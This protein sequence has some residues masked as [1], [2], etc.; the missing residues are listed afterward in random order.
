MG[1]FRPLSPMLHGDVVVDHAS[2]ERP[3]AIEGVDGHDVKKVI[4]LHPLEEIA[5]TAALELEDALGFPAA[6]ESECR[7]IG[8]RK[9]QRVGA[10][11]GGGGNDFDCLAHH[12]EKLQPQKVHLHQP[13]AFHVAHGPLRDHFL[14]ARHPLQRHILHQRPIG[15]HHRRRVRAHIAGQAL[16]PSGQIDQLSNLGIGF[17]GGGQL[18]ARRR[19]LLQRDAELIGH[20]RHNLINPLDRHAE[21]AAHVANGGP[22]GQRAKR[23]D[24]GHVGSPVAALHIFNHLAATFLAEID[25]DIGRLAPVDIEKPL[26]EQVVFQWADVREVEGVGHQRTNTRTSRRRWNP[27]LAGIAHE[28]PDNQEVTAKA[29]RVDDTHFPVKPIHHLRMERARFRAAGNR[30]IAPALRHAGIS[31]AQP[32]HAE[33]P[34]FVSGSAPFGH[35]ESREMAFA[36]IDLDI[37]GVGDLLA[38]G[39][40]CLGDLP[41]HVG[42]GGVHLGRTLQIKLRGVHPHPGG[43]AAE[44]AGVDAQEN[45]LGLGILAVDVVAVAGGHRRDAQFLRHF[46]SRERHLPLHLQAIVLNLDKIPIAKHL[47]KPSGGLPGLLHR[48]PLLTPHADQ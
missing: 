42:K 18:G 47:A 4:G 13:G 26:E 2:F 41:L 21:G 23:A 36:E 9:E 11:A 31:L 12:G 33:A 34:Q 17:A 27:H 22:G 14:L 38:A 45:V 15:D 10:G 7:L 46:Q 25:V 44:P 28:I 6:Q 5:N 3:R 24:L 1:I 32:L 29:E 37:D 19:S 30:R 16:D 8:E 43:I 35:I 39:H 48:L 40:S 20:Q